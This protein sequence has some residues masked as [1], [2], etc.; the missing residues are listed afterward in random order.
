MKPGDVVAWLYQG[1]AIILCECMIPEHCT[2]EEFHEQFSNLEEQIDIT[3]PEE[4]GWTIKLIATGEL[5]AVHEDTLHTDFEIDE[6]IA[7]FIV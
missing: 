5:I 6:K 2:I 1:P 7:A 3:L 4:Q